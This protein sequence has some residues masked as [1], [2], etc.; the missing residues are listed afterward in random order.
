MCCIVAPSFAFD[1]NHVQSLETHDSTLSRTQP[2][3]HHLPRLLPATASTESSSNPPPSPISNT[4]RRKSR[5]RYPLVTPFQDCVGQFG[6]VTEIRFKRPHNGRVNGYIKFNWPQE[7]SHADRS[8]MAP[9]ARQNEEA[10]SRLL[11]TARPS[12]SNTVA[13]AT[14]INSLPLPTAS[15]SPTPVS[16]TLSDV[17]A[18]FAMG[19][20]GA[21]SPTLSEEEMQQSTAQDHPQFLPS[22]FGYGAKM[23]FMD[24][25]FWTFCEFATHPLD[26]VSGKGHLARSQ[27]RT[28]IMAV[29]KQ[30]AC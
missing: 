4:S 22:Q 25:M 23:D 13:K 19:R 2:L 28:S 20:S 16:P 5:S 1:V 27:P 15:V 14:V 9:A 30:N 8:A 24:R 6:K 17:S 7:R 29:T 10:S 12:Q 11:P 3:Q 26:F 21:P 18:S